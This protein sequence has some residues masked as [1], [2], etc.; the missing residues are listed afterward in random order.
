MAH[1]AA[2]TSGQSTTAAASVPAWRRLRIVQAFLGDFDR[3]LARGDVDF[4]RDGVR[5]NLAALWLDD[6][7]FADL[8]RDLAR[9]IQPRLANPPRPGRKRRIL[10][11]VLLPGDEASRR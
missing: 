10:G 4:L 6:A 2:K 8:L 11:S 7:E 9:V 1:S 5:Y 3:Y